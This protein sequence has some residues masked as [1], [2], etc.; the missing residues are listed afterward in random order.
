MKLFANVSPHVAAASADS[1]SLDELPDELLAHI[2]SLLPLGSVPSAAAA[3]RSLAGALCEPVWKAHLCRLM[4]LAPERTSGRAP[5]LQQRPGGGNPPCWRRLLQIYAPP[6][7]ALIVHCSESKRLE[8]HSL[9]CVF[10][11]KLG[12]DRAVRT[13]RPLA[14]CPFSALRTYP[15]EIAG[16][17]G[18]PA[19]A[20]ACA[21]PNRLWVES[22]TV[23]YFEVS[24]G[25]IAENRGGELPESATH[26]APCVSV[27]L[28]TASFPLQRKQ[29]GWDQHSIGYHGDDGHIFHGGGLG[30]GRHGPP[31]GSGDTVGCGIHLP[32][33]RIFFTL[34]ERFVGSAFRLACPPDTQ[35]Y[36]TVGIDSHQ[37][38]SLNFGERPFAFEVRSAAALV[39]EEAVRLGAW[40][41]PLRI[42]DAFERAAYAS[43]EAGSDDESAYYDYFDDEDEEDEGEPEEEEVG[44][45][46]A[47]AGDGE[48]D[49]CDEDDEDDEDDEELESG[50]PL[51]VGPGVTGIG[52]M[53]GFYA[54]NP[55]GH[56]ILG[57]A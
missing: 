48:G 11:G 46:M 33:R 44:E 19:S 14:P 24:I 20:S 36:P 13:N 40:S 38:L 2:L 55:A 26:R 21:G 54:G 39:V 1:P 16:G 23:A 49:E 9:S 32:T 50:E 15:A 12:G 6:P 17:G 18:S 37:H 3:S 28:S 34:N 53:F 52:G 10:T 29:A 5:E 51:G 30:L 27:G 8:A 31:F 7:T 57:F 42:P 47:V 35:L 43:S 4:G 41:S 25:A 56:G 45:A 22:C